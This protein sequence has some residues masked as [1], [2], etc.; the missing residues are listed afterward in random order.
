MFDRLSIGDVFPLLYDAENPKKNLP[1]LSKRKRSQKWKFWNPPEK[2]KFQPLSRKGEAISLVFGFCMV[3]LLYIFQIFASSFVDEASRLY[4]PIQEMGGCLPWKVF[5]WSL[6]GYLTF[7]GWG[8]TRQQDRLIDKYKE[9][10]DQKVYFELKVQMNLAACLHCGRYFVPGTTLCPYCENYT[11]LGKRRM[12][13]SG[14]GIIYAGLG[15]IFEFLVANRPGLD[16]F[17]F[18]FGLLGVAG[19]FFFNGWREHHFWKSLRN[20]SVH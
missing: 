16:S 8:I 7:W 17:I 20:W 18:L 13:L 2:I 1:Q 9:E 12:F 4:A 5:I 6:L 19:M 15:L 3:L 14:L 10:I 11:N